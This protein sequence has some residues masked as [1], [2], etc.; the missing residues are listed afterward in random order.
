MLQH[1]NEIEWSLL[2]WQI[3]ILVFFIFIGR[4]FYLLYKFLRNNKQKT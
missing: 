1:I 4:L 3:L 2:L